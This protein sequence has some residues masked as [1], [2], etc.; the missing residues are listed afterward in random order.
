[1]SN[2]FFEAKSKGLTDE[3]Y[4]LWQAIVAKE[5]EKSDSRNFRSGV[6]LLLQ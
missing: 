6:W 5:C 1:V 4:G 3:A 2:M